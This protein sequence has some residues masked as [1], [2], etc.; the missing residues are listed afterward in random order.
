MT[1]LVLIA[2]FGFV[3]PSLADYREVIEFLQAISITGWLV[4]GAAAMFFLLAYP[5]VLVQVIPTLRFRESFVNHMAGTAV[6]N[7]VPSGG[8]IALPLNYAMYMSWGITPHAISAGLLTAGI[9]DWLGR[10]LLPVLAVVGVALIGD[11]LG[12]MWLVSGAGV[13]IV[14]VM[15][16]TLMKLTGS[17]KATERFVAF[18]E[19]LTA[20]GAR[21]LR[22]EAPDVAPTIVTFRNDLSSVLR[23]RG[24]RL[25]GATIMNHVAM[26]T[27]FVASVYG[28]GVTSDLIPL[29]WMILAFTLGRFLVM[30]PV[31]P[32]GIGLVDL[33][34]IGLLTLGWQTVNPG[35]PVDAS[36]ISAGVLLFRALSLLPPIPIGMA[37]WLFWRFNTS[38]RRSWQIAQRGNSGVV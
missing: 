10:I 14:S 26:A 34:W 30:I 20:W 2:V 3:I 4:I 19:R 7:T 36:L 21:R 25:T 31:S 29:P 28:V 22:K 32:G 9:W 1:A 13:I 37:T 38:W 17:E 12:W 6:T 16:F 23:I 27:L 15:V 24:L 5:V 8:A 35:T 18:A 33:G 11:A